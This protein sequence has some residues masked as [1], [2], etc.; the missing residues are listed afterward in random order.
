MQTNEYIPSTLLKPF[1]KSYRIIKSDSE[2]VNRIVP[3]T[4]FAMVFRFGGQIA[5]LSQTGKVPFVTATFSGL[6][7]SVRL[8]N[9][10]PN[11]QSLIIL[12]TETGVSSFF[13]QPLHELFEQS[14]ALD[15]FYPR[16]E[17][18]LL[19]ERLAEAE[20][21]AAKI[22]I[23]EQFLL[24]K[25]IDQKPDRLIAE[26][27]ARIHTA[28]GNNRI[29]ELAG[30]LY[31]SQDAFEKRFRKITG[32]TPKQF[33][34]IVKMESIVRSKNTAT[35]FLDMA[36]AN[37]YFDQAHFNKDFKLFTGLTPTDFFQA[38]TFW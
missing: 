35:S 18:A 28:R 34:G 2:L 6:R 32:A 14:I 17:V 8:I 37:G 4:S 38:A 9:Y 13:K 7:K 20:T 26:A 12:F 31:I 10:A 3:N 27:I 5:N 19:E 23:I 11:T 16:A 30:S 22:D 36:H 24:S 29:S 25:L 1:V 33:S 15:N 21:P